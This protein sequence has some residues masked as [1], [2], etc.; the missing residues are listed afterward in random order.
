MRFNLIWREQELCSAYG[1]RLK[2]W[3]PELKNDRRRERRRASLTGNTPQ[4]AP[5]LLR[6]TTH[7]GPVFPGPRASLSRPP[8][9]QVS[10]P[11][12]ACARV[13]ASISRRSARRARLPISPP[14]VA[15]KPPHA[16]PSCRVYRT[17]GPAITLQCRSVFFGI[18][19]CNP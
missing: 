2:K 3:Q 9:L 19:R 13:S 6:P 8:G 5:P 18:P 14:S 1:A 10:G 4:S 12:F 7:P 15:I 11:S 17:P 16:D